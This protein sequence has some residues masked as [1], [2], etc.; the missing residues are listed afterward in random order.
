MI[1]VSDNAL[2]RFLEHA[3]GL[4]VEQLRDELQASFA[5][6]HGAAMTLG[7]SDYAIRSGGNTFIVRRQTVTTV[8]PDDRLTVTARFHA[9]APLARSNG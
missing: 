3:A 6:A 9:L 8:I 7:V 1:R 5:R 2:L 4:D